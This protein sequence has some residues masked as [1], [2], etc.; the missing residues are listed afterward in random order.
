M[1]FKVTGKTAIIVV[2]IVFC[3]GVYRYA[4]MSEILDAKAKQPIEEYLLSTYL[5]QHM[6]QL[7]AFKKDG[8]T[9]VEAQ[10]LVT[11]SKAL[12]NIEVTE[13]SARSSGDRE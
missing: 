13:M 4:N 12:N 6:Q 1:R 9:E 8:I 5:G 2:I 11:A 3:Y 7:D 10:Q